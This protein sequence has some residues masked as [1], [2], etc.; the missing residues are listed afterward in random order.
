M[1]ASHLGQREQRGAGRVEPA[2]DLDDCFY[3]HVEALDGTVLGA[4]H[5]DATRG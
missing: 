2:R 5:A 1:P 4:I 3:G